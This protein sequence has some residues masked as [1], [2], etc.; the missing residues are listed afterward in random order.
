MATPLWGQTRPGWGWGLGGIFMILGTN[1][2]TFLTGNLAHGAIFGVKVYFALGSIIS[3]LHVAIIQGVG[4]QTLAKV[5][6]V[7]GHFFVWSG[8]L[9]LTY[10]VISLWF[11]CGLSHRSRETRCIRALGMWPARAS[12]ARGFISPLFITT[13][14]PPSSPATMP[15]AL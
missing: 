14:M 2:A 3:L 12:W 13:I 11:T 1:H 7:G 8:Q 6:Y 5:R 15:M 9:Q 10:F 4:F